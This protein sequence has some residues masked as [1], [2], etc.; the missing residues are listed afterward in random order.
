MPAKSLSHRRGSALILV[1]WCLLLL[2]MAVF[3]VVE[4]VELSVEHTSKSELIL[5]ARALATS[6]LAIGLSPQLL[7]D[8]PL[9]SQ[10]PEPGRQFKVTIRSEGARLNLNHVLQSGHREILVNLFTRWGLHQDEAD[11]VA[12]CLYDWITPGDLRSLNGAK[13]ADYQKAGLDQVPT[14]KPFVSLEEVDLVMNM[15]L[16]DKAKPDWADSFTLWSSGPLN[17]NEAPA[18]LIAAVFDLDPTRVV[19]FTDARNG[20]DGIPGTSDDVSVKNMASLQQQ[21]GLDELTVK[22]LG[23]QISFNDPNRRVESVGQADGTQ[24]MISVVTPLNSTPIQ[25]L[26]WSEQ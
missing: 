7:R 11:R 10:N 6:G 20:K 22:A 18:E 3:G 14:Y 15:N 17:V 23:G 19:F 1:L 21:L 4:M 13:A 25:Y 9:L 26:V 24:V 8:D 12:D 16:L 5:Q 2:G